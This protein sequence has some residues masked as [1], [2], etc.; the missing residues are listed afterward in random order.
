M[1]T[2]VVELMKLHIIEIPT[3]IA[4][5]KHLEIKDDSLALLKVLILYRFYLLLQF[6]EVFLFEF[7]GNTCKTRIRFAGITYI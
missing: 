2:S 7:K 6:Q 5:R 3:I 4:G 1:V